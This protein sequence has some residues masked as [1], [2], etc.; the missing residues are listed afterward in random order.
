MKKKKI[1]IIISVLM[2]LIVVIGISLYFS[3]KPK[4]DENMLYSKQF[5]NTI[6]KFQRYDYTLGQNMLVGVEKSTDKGKTYT[7]VTT[8]PITVSNKAEFIFINKTLS[9]VISTKNISKSNNSMGLKVS[10]DGGK[11][12]ENATFN[13]ENER[14]DIIT[15][16]GL[17][18]YDNNVLKLKCSVYDINSTRDG[19]EN[20]KLI[21]ISKDQGLTWNLDNGNNDNIPNNGTA[22]TVGANMENHRGDVAYF[23]A[24]TD[25]YVV[26][27]KAT[28]WGN[29]N[30]IAYT[31]QS[32]G[33]DGVNDGKGSFKKLVFENNSQA[34]KFADDKNG[35]IKVKGYIAIDNV[36]YI[37]INSGFAFDFETG[38]SFYYSK[39]NFI[40]DKNSFDNYYMSKP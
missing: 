26:Y 15:I 6:L 8:D 25:D 28:T 30:Y 37:D 20:V 33:P 12:F 27:T 24:T 10:Q 19:Y 21:F 18:Y 11:T 16:E 2:F 39:A 13:Y 4:V 31:I 22:P 17:P 38:I 35:N 7:T 5:G 14:V 36:V 34:K 9:F 40:N 32:F 3:N 29:Y 23:Y 1:F